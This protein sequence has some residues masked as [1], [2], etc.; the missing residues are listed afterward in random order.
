MS[1]SPA[2][3]IS[4][5]LNDLMRTDLAAIADSGDSPQEGA[6]DGL[7]PQLIDVLQALTDGQQLLLRRLRE[8]RPDIADHQSQVVEESAP[9]EVP[10]PADTPSFSG[11]SGA[12]IGL[13]Q[14]TSSGRTEVDESTSESAVYKDILAEPSLEPS[15]MTPAAGSPEAAKSQSVAS[16]VTPV[17][18][19]ADALNER[20][21]QTEWISSRAPNGTST[22][23][24]SRD[25]N[26]FDELDARLADLP[27]PDAGDA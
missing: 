22:S 10:R 5:P 25:Y 3:S 8:S 14:P 16:T 21:T 6:A 27:D 15:P 20:P 26:F 17:D 1:S 12:S 11:A 4:P 23:L 2:P 18:V 9:D 13:G 7:F 24:G 19:P